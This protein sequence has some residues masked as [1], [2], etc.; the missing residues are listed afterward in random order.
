MI[1]RPPRSTRTDT[2]FPY[3]T[4]FRSLVVEVILP[5]AG[6]ALAQKALRV[7]LARLPAAGGDGEGVAADDGGHGGLGGIA[8]EPPEEALHLA[9]RLVQQALVAPRI[10]V[11][12]VRLGIP[13][14]P[15]PG[16]A[17]GG[18]AV[19]AAAEGVGAIGG[20]QRLAEIGRAHV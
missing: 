8:A 14:E 12:V 19:F 3:T 16:V 1:R 2:L 18:G 15:R 6:D 4:L 11:P 10:G 20:R 7:G 17:P 9:R 5:V 13:A